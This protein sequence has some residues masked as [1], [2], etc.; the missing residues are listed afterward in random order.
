[1]IRKL[2][3]CLT[4]LSATFAHAQNLPQS[5]NTCG[6]GAPPQEWENWLSAKVEEFKRNQEN[7][8]GKSAVVSI[9]VIVH[10]LYY[11]EPIGTFPNIDTNQVKDQIAI[12]NRDFAGNGLNVNNVPSAF[13]GL[14]ANTGIEFCL[15]VKDEQEQP[16]VPHGMRRIGLAANGW[17]NVT[18]PTLNL[19]EYLNTVI[20]PTTRWD[21]TKYLNIWVSDK[22]PGYPLNGF[23]TYPP[24]S[25]LTGVFGGNIGT[26]NND[27]VWIWTSALGTAST[28]A[29][30]PFDEGRTGTHE[31]GHWLGLR[32]IWGDG[33]CLSD[34]CGDTPTSKAPHYGC[35][36]STP[37]DR[38]GV[39][40]SPHGEMP[41]NFMDRTDD[42]CM[43]MF[44]P[45]QT[46]RMKTALSQSPLRY[47]LGTHGKC[48]QIAAPS[49]PA[50]ASFTV[51][52]TQCIDKPFTPF[53]TT[54][55]YPL[56]TYVWSS[57][58]PLSFFPNNT[59]HNPAI[60]INSP[61]FYTLSLVATNSLTSSTATFIVSAQNTCVTQPFCLD[62]LKMVRNVDSVKAYK[63]PLSG[64]SNCGSPTTSGYLIGS[65]CYKDREVAQFFPA[66]SYSNAPNPQVNSV[67]V[68]FDSIGTKG[69][70]PATQISCKIYGGSLGSGPGAS[71]GFKNDSIGKITQSDV[72]T[73][74]DYMG[75]PDLS[76]NLNTRFYP[77]KFDFASPIVISNP[78][79]GFY[80]GIQVPNTPGDSISIMCSTKYN[81]VQD[82]N[83]W[84]LSANLNWKRYKSERGARVQLAVIPIVTCGPLGI[85]EPF[86]SLFNSNI[87]VMPNPSNG[88]FNIVFTLPKEES[89]SINIYSS[90]GQRVVSTEIKHVMNNVIDINLNDKP[91]G[92][93][94]AEISNG[95]EKTVRKLV[96]QH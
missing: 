74:V 34:Y 20:I 32:H 33:N 45:D 93:Y 95:L 31:V 28:G 94:F 49:Y 69:A 62:S 66:S 24:A 46:V 91:D 73:Y 92:I 7:T 90:V 14:V 52:A 35:V 26:M 72:V 57:S 39:G 68:L 96:V 41:M 6:T 2:L 54:S 17:L 4:V 70:N 19:Q 25:G 40:T 43:Y 60:T 75:K 3:I 63:A 78:S 58:P 86:T 37:P 59:V 64:V 82:S 11:N 80:T 87:H 53:N 30:A 84:F 79:S 8:Q 65:N 22:P 12:L 42:A 76:V 15:A 55:G 21:P 83:A 47:Q 50:A 18:T 89:V 51:G 61:G 29:I 38:C 88:A 23:A 81:S 1:M 67:I 27:G 85:K 56:P 9:P 36:T 71:Q 13:S 77:F 5:P 48:E 16:M 10:I 44:T